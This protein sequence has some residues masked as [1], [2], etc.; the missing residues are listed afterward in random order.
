MNNQDSLI[1][2]YMIKK[3]DIQ[4]IL[5]YLKINKRMKSIKKYSF[6]HDLLH[7]LRHLIQ[8]ERCE[9]V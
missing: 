6:I 8:L 7:N 3:F 5:G 4:F 9:N 1:T 2:G